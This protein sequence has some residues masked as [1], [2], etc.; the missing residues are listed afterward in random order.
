MHDRSIYPYSQIQILV[1]Y[2]ITLTVLIFLFLFLFSLS[3][4]LPHF[5]SILSFATRDR[6]IDYPPNYQQT[7]VA[8]VTLYPKLKYCHLGTYAQE[9]RAILI[10]PYPSNGRTNIPVDT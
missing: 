5:V 7:K 1:R 8:D 9:V 3:L 10:N 6:G 2:N 4:S